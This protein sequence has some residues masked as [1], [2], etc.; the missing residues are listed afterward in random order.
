MK[1]TQSN[2]VTQEKTRV[3]VS[4]EQFT[5]LIHYSIIHFKTFVMTTYDMYTDR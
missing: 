1:N 3:R 5:K 2:G 4:E